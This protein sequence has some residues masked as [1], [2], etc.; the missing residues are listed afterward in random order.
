MS[1]YGTRGNKL[2]RI[3]GKSKSNLLRLKARCIGTK[4]KAKNTIENLTNT[5]ISV[6]G[7]TISII[8]LAEQV[9]LAK[10]AIEALLRGSKHGNV[11]KQLEKSKSRFKKEL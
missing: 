11:Y 4:G 7:K 6:Y 8:G 3:S 9:F 5:S 10:K 1:S 2:Q